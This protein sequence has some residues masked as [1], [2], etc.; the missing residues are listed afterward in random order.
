IASI[1]AGSVSSVG[2]PG[3][4]ASARSHGSGSNPAV[5][6]RRVSPTDRS[7]IIPPHAPPTGSIVNAA[8]GLR[9]TGP[10]PGAGVLA[11][12]D[13]TGAGGAA[14]GPV[15]VGDGWMPAQP[16]ALEIGFDVGRL[17]TRQRIDA[18]LALD[19]REG[20]QAGARLGL[21]ALAPGKP[22]GI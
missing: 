21:E 11:R 16:M 7:A 10:A 3:W 8:F 15:A 6:H 18:Q 19:I 9:E 5:L 14:D 13:R 12:R 17:P 20:G 2:R 4:A 1:Q 22:G